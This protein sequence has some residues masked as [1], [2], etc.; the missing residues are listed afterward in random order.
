MGSKIQAHCNSSIMPSDTILDTQVSTHRFIC[1]ILYAAHGIER[2]KNCELIATLIDKINKIR[3]WA[4]VELDTTYIICK[5]GK[6]PT[7]NLAFS[8]KFIDLFAGLGGFHLALTELGHECV[9]ASEIDPVLKSTYEKNFD[10]LPHGD[11]REILPSEIPAHD[12]LCAGFPCQPFSKAGEQKGL[13]CPRNG[14]LFDQVLS[15]LKHHKPRYVILEN[16][17]NLSMH[18]GGKTWTK[19]KKKLGEIYHISES[20][21]SPHHFGI[22]QIR[23]RIF[24]VGVSKASCAQDLAN[25]KWPAHT[26]KKDLSI[27][28]VLDR[29]PQNARPLTKQVI[30]C[31]EAMQKFVEAFPKDQELPSFPIWT[32]EFGATYPYKDITPFETGVRKLAN[33]KGS[34]GKKLSEVPQSKRFEALPSHARTEEE[35]FPDWKIDFIKQNRDLY[36]NNKEWID[37]WMP[38]ILKFPPSLQKLEWNVKGEERNIWNYVIQFRASGVRVKR[39]NSAPS[40]VAM[41]TTQVPI[42]A[43]EKRYMTPKE[44]ARLQ[45]M[46]DL[47]HLPETETK[48]FKALG[49]AVN[50]KVVR[51]I[52]AELFSQT[53]Q[54]TVAA[55]YVPVMRRNYAAEA[56][57]M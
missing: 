8:M 27:K 32:M 6:S 11:I 14:D 57:A 44:C 1:C 29:N 40:L 47:K 17:P 34:H 9:F 41:T 51:L 12:I 48:A 25:F 26:Q 37:K 28:D 43:W 19:M 20:K 5:K 55:T 18:N 3:L 52:A 2:A 4:N 15:I 31:L 30:E 16:V 42:I 10:I 23:E 22:P 39:C 45:S 21:L 49:N 24:I 7:P 54:V 46:G 56:R 36:K 13:K 38:Q 53:K 35:K 50:A 33:F